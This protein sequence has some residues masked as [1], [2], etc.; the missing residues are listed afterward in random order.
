MSC[1]HPLAAVK[2]GNL[3]DS[4]KEE[5]QIIRSYTPELEENFGKDLTLIPCGHC[6]G[7]RLD[8]SRR[9]ANRMMFEL[10]HCNNK[11][12]F[13]TLTYNQENVPKIYNTDSNG[14]L[15]DSIKAYTLRKKD[16]QDFMKRLR[17]RKKFEGREIKFYLAGEYGENTYRPHLHAILFN[18]GLEDFPD[19]EF[20]GVN[21]FGDP[22]YISEEFADIWSNGYIVLS[23]VSWKT[24]A[25]VSRYVQ[26][27]A[28]NGNGMLFEMLGV[29]PE[30]SLM[31]R[32]P[33]IGNQFF[34]DHPELKEFTNFYLNDGQ[35]S[36]KIPIS[37]QL[38]DKIYASDPEKYADIKEC[39]KLYA[40]DKLMLELAKTD[41]GFAEYMDKK[42]EE[43]LSRLT[44]L[45]RAKV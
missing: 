39:N 26:K 37:K 44:S 14:E 9:W 30:F 17:G 21:E 31:S 11:A 3:T 4:G 34:E 13:C 25:Y 28:I 5:Y 45:K 42:E 27:K 24:C 20:F 33:G 8:Y 18:V 40:H 16:A 15:T 41:L 2:T 35:E 23:K 7:C 19:R 38:M 32:R 22:Y 29:D 1:Y 12:V 6:L 10:D 43:H 36:V